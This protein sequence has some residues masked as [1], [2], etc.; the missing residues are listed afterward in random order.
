VLSVSLV[1]ANIVQGLLPGTGF[2][3]TFLVWLNLAPALVYAAL[4]MRHGVRHRVTGIGFVAA[5][6]LCASM[7]PSMQ[8][9]GA[10]GWATAVGPWEPT[11]RA[12]AMLGLTMGMV[13]GLAEQ[14]GT[15]SR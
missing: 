3:H 13:L 7:W 5:G 12:L 8:G 1:A 14:F 2:A 4:A 11:V 10:A 9:L 15:C 6:V